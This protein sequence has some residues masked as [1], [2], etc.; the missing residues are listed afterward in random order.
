QSMLSS[1]LLPSPPSRCSLSG[2]GDSAAVCCACSRSGGGAVGGGGARS[3]PS[4]SS[5]SSIGFS[6]R[7]RSISW[8]SSIVDNCSSLMDCCSC[9]VSV[10][11]WESLSWRLGFI[12]MGRCAPSEADVLAEMDLA[13]PFVVHD[14]AG[15]ACG[16][17]A[18]L[19]DDV[20]A[21]ADAE[22]LAHVV[23]GDQHADAALLE[24]ADDLLDV[25]D[26]DR[27]DAGE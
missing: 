11:C 25:D 2:A 18:S 4:P 26:R 5:R 10:R 21:V 3:A 7:M 9:G 17:H 27:V 15:F 22:G 24:E 19:A 16:Q 20:G 12:A 1:A 23:V 8:F 14:L 13:H 6:N